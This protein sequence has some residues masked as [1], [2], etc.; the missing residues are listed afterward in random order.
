MSSLDFEPP[1]TT[2][3]YNLEEIISYPNGR[4]ITLGR[5]FELLRKHPRFARVLDDFVSNPRRTG[6]PEKEMRELAHM[7]PLHLLYTPACGYLG[8]PDADRTPAE[9]DTAC[10]VTKLP[11]LPDE[12]DL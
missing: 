1:L 6:L 12:E 3:P 4:S 7:P 9:P 11:T 5:W 8:G 10:D 2:S